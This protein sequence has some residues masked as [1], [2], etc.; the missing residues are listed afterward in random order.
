[1]KSLFKLLCVSFLIA[2]LCSD[3]LADSKKKAVK[4]SAQQLSKFDLGKYQYCG[5]DSDCV[6]VQNGCCD[7]ANGGSDVAINKIHLEDF[8]ARFHCEDVMC[9][10][11]AKIPPCGSGVVSCVNHECRYVQESDAVMIPPVE[12]LTTQASEE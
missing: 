9:T 8:K 11:R 1:M 7:C 5:E 10:A 2:G 12:K 6:A 3:V 4:S